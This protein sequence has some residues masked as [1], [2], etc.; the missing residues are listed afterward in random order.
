MTI[1][2]E[3]IWD[4]FNTKKPIAID[5]KWLKE[6]YS[7]E[8]STK[9]RSTIGERLGLFGEKGWEAIKFLIDKNG[10][11]P[12]LINAAGL[13]HQ[14]AAFD[15]LLKLL[16]TQNNPE[17]TIVRALACWGAIIP[18]TD[19][20]KILKENSMK[21]R[22]AGLNLLSFKSHLLNASELLELIKDL[23]EDF[24]EEVIIQV[25]KILQRRNEEEIVI[26]IS[27]LASNGTDKVVEAALIALGTIGTEQSSLA[28]ATLCRELHDK[29]HREIAQK[30]LSH[31]YI[32]P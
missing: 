5:P 13:C 32:N 11:Q 24:R 31:Q 3:Q 28:L 21:M 29:T 27:E 12:E 6:I 20:K 30:Q 10:A 2:E 17:I 25:I 15:F 18:T 1:T 4:V 9:L 8:M 22:L 26:C 14:T 7:L 16:R 19:I 23:L